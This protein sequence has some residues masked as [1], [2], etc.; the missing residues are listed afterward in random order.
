MMNKKYNIL[1]IVIVALMVGCSSKVDESEV[2]ILTDVEEVSNEALFSEEDLKTFETIKGF[3]P[4]FFYSQKY[5]LSLD[6][7]KN[8]KF[9]FDDKTYNEMYISYE[10]EYR[11]DRKMVI[12][13]YD[14]GT[15]HRGYITYRVVD[16]NTVLKNQ[17][18]WGTSAW[19]YYLYINGE[20]VFEEY[21]DHNFYTQ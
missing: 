21:R 1:F 4:E 11:S 9:D 3:Y 19:G 10:A 20:K 2:A 12:C 14:A 17:E 15:S 18:S 6:K 5:E 7:W 13:A 16:E 8:M